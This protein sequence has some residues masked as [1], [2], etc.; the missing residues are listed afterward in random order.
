[1]LICSAVAMEGP[2]RP[3][4]PN[5]FLCPSFRF[6]QNTSLEHHV[7]TRQQIQMEKEIKTFKRKS[8]LKFSRLFAKLLATN[9]CT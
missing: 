5:D 1:M 2:G 4:S 6:D 7:T 8:R 9:C 3:C